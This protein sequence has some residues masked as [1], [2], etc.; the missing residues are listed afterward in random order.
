MTLE[1]GTGPSRIVIEVAAGAPP[2][3]ITT[4][5]DMGR[6]TWLTEKD[7]RQ[8]RGLRLIGAIL[9]GIALVA[10]LIAPAR[11]SLPIVDP[12]GGCAPGIVC[13]QG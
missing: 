1:R 4:P 6:L 13:R 9:L 8:G 3:E 12:R 11:R 2:P 7:L 5:T 10:G